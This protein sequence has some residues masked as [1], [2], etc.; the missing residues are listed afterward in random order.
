MI[1]IETSKELK[2]NVIITSC[3]TITQSIS[4]ST[5]N[6]IGFGK[7]FIFTFRGVKISG[8]K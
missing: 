4:P 6:S 2:K 7:I 1:L 5:E 8:S 3:E